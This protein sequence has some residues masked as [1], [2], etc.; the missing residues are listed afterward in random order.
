ML[1]WHDQFGPMHADR[2][3]AEYSKWYPNP[4]TRSGKYGWQG[5]PKLILYALASAGLL[6]FDR[7]SL[8][9]SITDSGRALLAAHAR[10]EVDT[11]PWQDV[12]RARSR[13]SFGKQ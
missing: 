9:A 3:S 10:G 13:L 11:K 12:K 5:T 8:I 2:L 7:A 1:R 4:N 6:K